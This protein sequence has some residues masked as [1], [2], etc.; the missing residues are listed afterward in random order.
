MEK[1]QSHHSFSAQALTFCSA[2]TTGSGK[3]P[4]CGFSSESHQLLACLHAEHIFIII[5][6]PIRLSPFF[7]VWAPKPGPPSCW[8]HTPRL[9]PRDLHFANFPHSLSCINLQFLGCIDDGRRWWERSLHWSRIFRAAEL[10][11]SALRGSLFPV[12]TF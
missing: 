3:I 5:S 10:P 8:L 12:T 1:M 2:V 9:P 7:S 11:H 4:A 6:I